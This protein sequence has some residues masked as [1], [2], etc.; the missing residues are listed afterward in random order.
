MKNIEHP[1][2]EVEPITLDNM[3]KYE[4]VFYCNHEYFMITDGRPATQSDCIQTIEYSIDGISKDK[5]HTIGF[6]DKE[7]PVACLSVIDGYPDT[8]TL[9]LGLFLVHSKYKR[10]YVGT[11][12][13]KAL[14]LSLKETD[15]K[16]IRLSVQ[17]NNTSGLSFWKH[18]G[19]SIVAKTEGENHNNYTMEYVI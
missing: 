12:L 7:E 11:E 4:D 2:Y 19:F 18:I 3:S 17:D 9:W 15:I 13:I 8:D 1:C 5:I 6:S 14:V 10:K 16:R